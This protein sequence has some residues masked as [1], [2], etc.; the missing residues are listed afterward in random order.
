MEQRKRLLSEAPSRSCAVLLNRLQQ[1]D[2]PETLRMLMLEDF[3][4]KVNGL[5]SS[6]RGANIAAAIATFLPDE[7][8]R[9][10]EYATSLPRTGERQMIDVAFVVVI[11]CELI[12]MQCALEIDSKALPSRIED[13]SRVWET[14]LINTA[15]GGEIEMTALVAMI[16]EAGNYSCAA[17]VSRLFSM[18]DVGFAVLCGIGAGVRAKVKLGDVVAGDTVIDYEYARLERDGIAQRPRTYSI[19]RRVARD[20]QHFDAPRMGW[21]RFLQRRRAAMRGDEFAALPDQAN[22]SWEP[23]FT[24]GV[25]LSGE[26]LIADG[27]LEGRRRALHER[28]RV[29]EMEGAGFAR[30]CEEQDVPWVVFRGIS[31]FGDELKSDDWHLASGLAAATAAVTFVRTTYSALV[32]EF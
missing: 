32:D 30:A 27:S 10:L 3:L 5:Q 4:T 16:G 15:S 25:V 21:T 29:A 14:T 7:V 28:I 1:R 12:A 8:R 24:M 31:D 2:S 11:P 26:K 9:R 6:A 13:G 23:Q 20:L 18:Y 17:S 22:D 19:G